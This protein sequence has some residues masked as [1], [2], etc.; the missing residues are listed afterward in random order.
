MVKMLYK[1]HSYNVG[2]IKKGDN[3]EYYIRKRL[4]NYISYSGTIWQKKAIIT[5]TAAQQ[6]NN[7]HVCVLD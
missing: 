2:Q 5:S 1:L 4:V 7:I 6:L 3:S